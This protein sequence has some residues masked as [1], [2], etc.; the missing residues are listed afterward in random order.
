MQFKSI[1][2]FKSCKIFFVFCKM[3]GDGSA[4]DLCSGNGNDGFIAFRFSEFHNACC[5]CE[6]CEIPADAYVLAGVVYGPALAQD[7]IACKCGLS[8]EYF[9]AESFAF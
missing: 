6:E 7:D 5:Q 9:Y 2:T 1:N 3:R 8:A 4:G